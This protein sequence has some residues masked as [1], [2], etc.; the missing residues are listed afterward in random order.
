MK[1]IRFVLF[2]FL[3]VWVIMTYCYCETSIIEVKSKEIFYSPAY[4]FELFVTG[5]DEYGNDKYCYKKL[6]FEEFFSNG[7]LF[8]GVFDYYYDCYAC[9][10]I[11]RKDGKYYVLG[12]SHIEIFEEG[13]EITHWFYPTFFIDWGFD[14]KTQEIYLNIDVKA[15]PEIPEE[16]VKPFQVKMITEKFLYE[17]IHGRRGNPNPAP[18]Q[19]VKPLQPDAIISE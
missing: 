1:K 3:L 18:L 13:N 4:G 10:A 17:K 9:S 8:D 14:L 19:R 12:F 16:S 15:L 2:F 5:I 11:Y 7:Y 6:P